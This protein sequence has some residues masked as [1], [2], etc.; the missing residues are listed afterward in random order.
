MSDLV[1]NPEDRFSRV[2]PHILHGCVFVMYRKKQNKKKH[3]QSSQCRL[4]FCV[5]DIMNI[6]CLEVLKQNKNIYN[7]LY[8]HHLI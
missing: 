2:Q 4:L 1:G 7:Y 3:T 6:A 8:I 5:L